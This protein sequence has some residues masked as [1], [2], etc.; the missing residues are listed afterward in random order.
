MPVLTGMRQNSSHTRQAKP[1]LHHAGWWGWC[2]W[3]VG[4]CG[5]VGQV[6]WCGGGAGAVCGLVVEPCKACRHKGQTVCH[7]GSMW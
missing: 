4:W 7:G 3:G 6:G 5:G 1:A 2:V